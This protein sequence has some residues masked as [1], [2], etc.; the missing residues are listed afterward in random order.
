MPVRT[1]MW[2]VNGLFRSH[3]IN[4]SSIIEKE[5]I[6]NISSNYSKPSSL[7]TISTG[8]SNM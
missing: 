7:S 6:E 5:N 8:I 2:T 3:N 4:V 1:E